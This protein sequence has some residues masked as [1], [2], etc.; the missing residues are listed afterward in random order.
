MTKISIN[1]NGIKREYDHIYE[2][3][4]AA[5]ESA[6][7]SGEELEEVTYT[8]V[9]AG[10][11]EINE[12]T[13]EADA[14]DIIFYNWI[15]LTRRYDCDPWDIADGFEPFNT[16]EDAAEYLAAHFADD[17]DSYRIMCEETTIYE[18]ITSYDDDVPA[19][20]RVLPDGSTEMDDD[21][22]QH[23]DCGMLGY[24]GW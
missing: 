13:C 21:Y 22:E 19:L 20:Y 23:T 15:V 14:G 4:T 8:V 18:S 1:I 16:F 12:V 9:N 7:A 3:I 17:L 24:P 5:Q 6:K 11:E 2:A 10:G